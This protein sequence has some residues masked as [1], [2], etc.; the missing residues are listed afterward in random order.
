MRKEE[1]LIQKY[2]QVEDGFSTVQ[3]YITKD[4]KE[5]KTEEEAIEHEASL[6]SL[7]EFDKKYHHFKKTLNGIDYDVLFIDE[8][9]R[10]NKIEILRMF[11]RINSDH[12]KH[13]VNLIYTDDTGDYTFQYV[14][15]V[16]DLLGSLENNI[17]EIKEFCK[18]L[19]YEPMFR[20][21][22]KESTSLQQLLS[23]AHPELFQEKAK[24]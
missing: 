22:D 15:H 16:D 21:Q 24:S 14:E 12:L 9:T 20:Y 18:E 13:G 23:K 3:V 4:N 2:R 1:K 6:I 7:E 17:K 10:L 19:Q 5:F 8:L 11:S